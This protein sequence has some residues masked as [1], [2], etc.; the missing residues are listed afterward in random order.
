MPG[1][2][3][4]RHSTHQPRAIMLELLMLGHTTQ[5]AGGKQEDIKTDVS[6][7]I[8]KYSNA[9]S[10]SA[11]NI[12]VG[13]SAG[14]AVYDNQLILINPGSMSYYDINTFALKKSTTNNVNIS[15]SF[16]S[17]AHQS[18]KHWWFGQD[19]TTAVIYH[20]DLETGVITK[21]PT[22]PV[23]KGMFF[24]YN[25]RLWL[26]GG[27]VGSVSNTTTIYSIDYSNPVSWSSQPLNTP[28]PR[29]LAGA[30][31]YF[32]TNG[33]VAFVGGGAVGSSGDTD[34]TGYTSVMLFNPDTLTFTGKTISTPM[35]GGYH[36]PN[37]VFN[38]TAYQFKYTNTG[39][40]WALGDASRESSLSPAPIIGGYH[41]AFTI[42]GRVAFYGNSY[43]TSPV[44]LYVL[45]D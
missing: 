12:T 21:Y 19:R 25:G 32:T 16:N 42:A 27:W 3:V 14:L 7:L 45:P 39:Q 18:G 33:L 31:A 35:G 23:K 26:V 41:N 44:Y 24:A 11:L 9:G 10:I 40:R 1:L 43:S 30:S 28:L 15:V 8:A 17:V 36:N 20:A 22:P 37:F 34:G 4:Y 29:Q 13:A 2:I 6:G 38:D 5:S